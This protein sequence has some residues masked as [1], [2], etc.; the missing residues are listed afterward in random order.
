MNS[1]GSRLSSIFN[2][3]N[4]SLNPVS[5]ELQQYR[6]IRV[7]VFNNNLERA[8]GVMQRM[9]QSSGIERLIKRPET[10]HIKNCE[11]RVLAKKLLQRKLQSQELARKLK[12]IL[13]KRIRGL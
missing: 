2:R 7:K 13:V 8:L 4:A 12:S 5:W 3:T 9:M 11:K 6:G 10:R 1:L